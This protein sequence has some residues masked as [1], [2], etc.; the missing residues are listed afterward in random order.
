MTK[1]F[2]IG[3]IMS[4]SFSLF[5]QISYEGC[6]NQ[7]TGP[8]PYTLSQSGTT[9][10]GGI[11]RNTYTSTS[12]SC[13]AG[14]CSYTIIWS[15]TNQRWE[16]LL[17]GSN[18]LHHNSTAS[19]PNPPSLTLG[20]WQNG[21]G[22]SGITTLSGDVQSVLPVDLVLFESKMID[23]QIALQ[24]ITATELNN[25]KFEVEESREGR[26]FQK[27][28]EVK[29]KGATHEQQDY[30]FE[31][32]NPRN[33]IS[34]YRLKQIDF[35][36][37]FEYSKVIRVNFK[38]EN[39]NVGEFYPNPSKSGTVNLDYTSENDDEILVS[40]FDVTG[41]LIVN[42]IQQFSNGDN[43]LSFDF[44]ELNTGIYIVKIGDERNPTHRK[45]IIER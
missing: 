37:Q 11:I 41:K 24:W 1:I 40:V 17:N 4:L 42:Q 34:Y 3:F 14:S 27:I 7:I 32:K 20:T 9:N 33:G 10:D 45:L 21:S 5:G 6:T 44:S 26:E 25:E 23:K 15:I 13:S 18:L 36:G 16:L 35:D 12:V 19:V 28:G 43:N 29:G 30:S 38:G 22:C 2:T 39:G 31:V 8:S